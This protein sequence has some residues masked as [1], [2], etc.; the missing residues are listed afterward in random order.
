VVRGASIDPAWL[1]G[2]AIPAVSGVECSAVYALV[3]RR[4]PDGVERVRVLGALGLDA[5]EVARD[6]EVS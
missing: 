4:V 6:A 2:D 3:A 1:S 5:V